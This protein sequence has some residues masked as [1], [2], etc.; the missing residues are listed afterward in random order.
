MGYFGDD[1]NEWAN[2]DST[3]L[4]KRYNGP[5]LTILIDQ[6]TADEWLESQLKQ[7]SKKFV[8]CA[9]GSNVIELGI[10]FA[11]SL[12]AF[13]AGRC[14]IEHARWLRPRLLLRGHIHS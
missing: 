7:S 4:V 9:I 6:G 14:P 2:W 3:E 11:E 8:E 12:I 13:S 10:A 5:P 1:R